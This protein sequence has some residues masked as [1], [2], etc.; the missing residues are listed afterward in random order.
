[1]CTENEDDEGYREVLEQLSEIVED[2]AIKTAITFPAGRALKEIDVLKYQTTAEPPVSACSAGSSPIIFPDGRV[3]ACIGPVID[4]KSDH[5]LLLGNLRENS[6]EEI[7]DVAELNPVLHA[8][9]I[10]GPK[11]LISMIQEGGLGK[12]LPERY[13]KNSVCN[14]CYSLM[15]N[16]AIVQFLEE[17]AEDFE[18]RRRVAYARVYYLSETRMVEL[19]NLISD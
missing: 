7:L 9:R 13:I 2:E 6:L 4:L 3:I 16:K 1:M 14:A 12:H 15:S 11:K 8:I 18:F 17:L 19:Q 5:P 10:W